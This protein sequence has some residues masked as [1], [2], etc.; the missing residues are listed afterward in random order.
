MKPIITADVISCFAHLMKA[1]NGDARTAKAQ[2]LTALGDKAEW[3]HIA[4]ANL[5]LDGAA[6]RFQRGSGHL[7]V[8]T[9]NGRALFARAF[10]KDFPADTSADKTAPISGATADKTPADKTPADA[11]PADAAPADKTPSQR[12]S[13]SPLSLGDKSTRSKADRAVKQ[14]IGAHGVTTIEQLMGFIDDKNLAL[15]EIRA[16]IQRGDI[17]AV[18]AATQRMR[19]IGP[20]A[21]SLQKW[22]DLAEKSEIPG[23]MGAA[24]PISEALRVSNHPLIDVKGILD[25][26]SDTVDAANAVQEKVREANR[27]KSLEVIS[28]ARSSASAQAAKEP[29]T[30]HDHTHP[31]EAVSAATV[32][33]DPEFSA[34]IPGEIMSATLQAASS[35]KTT[36]IEAAAIFT[37]YDGHEAS[38]MLDFT[39]PFYEVSGP[40]AADIPEIDETYQFLGEVLV[41]GLHSIKMNEIIWLFGDSGSGKSEF[42]RQ[43]AARLGMPF[44]RMNMDGHL[45][46]SDVVGVNRLI[47]GPNGAPTMR[48]IDGILPRAMARPGLLLIDELDLGDP[49]I[50]PIL[51]PILEGG[52]LRILEDGGREVRPHPLFRIAITGNS[53]GLGAGAGGYVNVHEQSAATRDRISAYVKMPYLPPE[54]E[55]KVV[56]SRNPKADAGFVRKLIQLAEKIRQGFATGEIGQTLSTRGVMAAAS[57]QTRLGSITSAVS[58]ADAEKRILETVILNRM[59]ES[60]RPIVVGLID[61]IFG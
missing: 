42:W 15:E 59:D 54:I 9:E 19:T 4:N 46:R 7:P 49:E 21:S 14:A 38:G 45:T 57:R 44:T 37:T 27:K 12:Q 5:I 13:F 47:P 33:P 31:A 1:H 30:G 39:V 32:T 35:A 16:G 22:A 43:L 20:V 23:I 55:I 60:S 17:E 51:Q 29:Y 48:F 28:A 24:N 61:N 26:L 25:L 52:A 34:A 36:D 2:I 40:A 53:T 41:E 10:G 8:I 11:A 18:N 56:M 50:M 6:Q 58:T 3:E